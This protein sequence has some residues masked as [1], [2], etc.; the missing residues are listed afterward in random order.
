M[1][2]L[3]S[4]SLK[5]TSVAMKTPPRDSSVMPSE[6]SCLI[7]APFIELFQYFAV[8]SS[9]NRSFC[10]SRITRETSSCLPLSKEEKTFF[11]CARFSYANHITCKCEPC[12]T[13][14]AYGC[15]PKISPTVEKLQFLQKRIKY[16]V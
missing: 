7:H 11:H 6:S 10:N 9:K 16:N 13:A 12:C 2:H 3:L 8:R 4:Y 14:R 1:K 5:P 15:S